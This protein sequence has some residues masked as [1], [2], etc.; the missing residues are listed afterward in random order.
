MVAR[1]RDELYTNGLA[2]VGSDACIKAL[3]RGQVDVLVL[4]TEH[5]PEDKEVMV[6]LAEQQGCKIET[7]NQSDILMQLGGVGCLLRYRPPESSNLE[8]SIAGEGSTSHEEKT[9]Q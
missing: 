6:R 5:N 8:P 9:I 1:L 4:A 7:V 2:V 3:E